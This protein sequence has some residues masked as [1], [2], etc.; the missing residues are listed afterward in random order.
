M[1]HYVRL[2]SNY[3]VV[4]RLVSLELHV[5]LVS[6]YYMFGLMIQVVALPKSYTGQNMNLKEKDQLRPEDFQ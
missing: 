4:C 5:Y 3:R 6:C 2:Y 1:Y